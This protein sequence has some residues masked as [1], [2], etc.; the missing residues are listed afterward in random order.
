[1]YL[2]NY[3]LVFSTDRRQRVEGKFSIFLSTILEVKNTSFFLNR[4]MEVHTDSQVVKFRFTRLTGIPDFIA[5]IVSTRDS[6]DAE[7]RNQV[8]VRMTEEYPKLGES[9]RKSESKWM[10]FL[11]GAIPVIQLLEPDPLKRKFGGANPPKISDVV[12]V[13]KGLGGKKQ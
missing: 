2:T 8:L 4:S 1:V 12:D 10:R 7:S 3:R 9:F 13:L 6:I 5:R 11:E